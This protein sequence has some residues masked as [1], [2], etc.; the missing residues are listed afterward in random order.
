LAEPGRRLLLG[1]DRCLFGYFVH[2]FRAG[3]PVSDTL[4]SF[5]ATVIGLVG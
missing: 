3:V 2:D 4:D 1:Q 5:G